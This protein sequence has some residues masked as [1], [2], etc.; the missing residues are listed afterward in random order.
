MKALSTLT[1]KETKT[2]IIILTLAFVIKLVLAF[3]I[4]V[5]LRSDSMVYDALAK[6]LVQKGEYSFEGSTTALLIPGYPIFLAGIYSI[7]G[8]DQVFVKIIQSLF[9]I[10]SAL[11]FFLISLRLFDKKYALI[12]VTIFSFFPSNILFSQT[13]LT[14][15]LFC[16]LQMTLLYLCICGNMPKN[17]FLLGLVWGAAIMVRTS[18]ALSILLIPLYLLI[19]RKEFFNGN[20]L[21]VVQFSSLFVVGVFIVLAPWLIR[22]QTTMGSFTL[23][24]QGGFT[25]WSGSNPDATGSWYYKIEESDPLFNEKDEVK[26][27]KEFYKRG[28]DYAIHNPHKWVITGVK[29]LGYLFSSERM[30]ILYFMDDP[31]EGQTSTQLYREANPVFNAVVNLPFFAIMLLGTWGLLSMRKNNYFIYGLVLTWIVTIFIFVALARYHYVLVPFFIIGTVRSLSLG[32]SMLSEMTLTRKLIAGAFSL[33]LI[34]VW[35]SEFYLLFKG[36]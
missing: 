7:F 10:I 6:N 31:G 33:F 22:N 12:S 26:R 16:L 27:D 5:E 9:E 30:I 25:F 4:H 14:E 19:K 2:L 28:I 34:G 29:K 32:K 36:G 3:T 21:K 35:A 18:F 11:L 15:P 13:I 24:T 8:S 23:A 20:Y 17:T 1:K